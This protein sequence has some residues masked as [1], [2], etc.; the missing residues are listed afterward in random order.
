MEAKYCN[1]IPTDGGKQI[2]KTFT[3][4]MS[5]KLAN[6]QFNCIVAPQFMCWV[7]TIK[8]N[9]KLLRQVA[10]NDCADEGAGD[11]GMIIVSCYTSLE[12]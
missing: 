8:G 11:Q 6:V 1:N 4:K 2:F 12:S 3:A 10:A 7:I 5:S 9:Y